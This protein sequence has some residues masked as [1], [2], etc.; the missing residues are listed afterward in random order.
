LLSRLRPTAASNGGARQI[1]NRIGA[2]PRAAELS[3]RRIPCHIESS[4][5][6]TFRPGFRTHQSAYCVPVACQSWHER[7]ADQSSRTCHQDL[8]RREY[9]DANEA[10]EADQPE[11]SGKMRL[12][13][14]AD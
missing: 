11:K 4:P 7:A 6:A 8:H 13:R 14:H 5:S 1:D 9:T 2:Y 10:K 3:D 12:I